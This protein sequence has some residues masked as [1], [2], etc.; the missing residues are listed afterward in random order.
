MANFVSNVNVGP[1]AGES[2]EI[3]RQRKLAEMLQAQSM[4]PLQAPQSG[5]LAAPISPLHILAKGLQA[6]K[7][8]QAETEATTKA[9]DLSK[10]QQ[11]ERQAALAA[12]LRQGMGAEAPAPEMGGGPAMPANPAQGMATLAQSG[13]PTT[14]SMGMGPLQAMQA[15]RMARLQAELRPKPAG[16][17]PQ[18]RDTPQGLMRIGAE[19]PAQPVM[20]PDNK[21][22]PTMPKT[23]L[24]S[25]VIDNR[26]PGDD[27]YLKERR[28]QQAT[29]YAELE[30]GAESA[31]KRM[32]TLDRFLEAS[33]KGTAGGVQPVITATQNFLASFGYSP[34]S[35]KNVAVMEQAIGDILGTKMQELGARGL[36]DRDMDI[37]RQALP[38]VAIAPEAREAVVGILKKADEFTLNEYVNVRDQEAK[39]YPDFAKKTPTQGWLRDYQ[40]RK[41]AGGAGGAQ[42]WSIRPLP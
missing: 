4:E 16:P 5:A 37:L 27:E 34:E 18:L 39:N 41:P 10:R 21:P 14:M 6:Y 20:G 22:I 1:Y 12:A 9:A 15:E 40:S 42:G 8:K 38:R 19:G 29:R 31:Y 26:Q 33:K 13:D 11:E 36:T 25:N 17:Q 24:V 7:G 30:K 3:A 28:K 35:L 23:P 32:Q 2:Q